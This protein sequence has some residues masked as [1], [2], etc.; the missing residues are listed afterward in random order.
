MGTYKHFRENSCKWGVEKEL[1][2]SIEP[3]LTEDSVKAYNHLGNEQSELKSGKQ[4]PLLPDMD[5]SINGI[6]NWEC[7]NHTNDSSICLK[8]CENDPDSV[9]GLV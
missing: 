9:E 7:S 3:S 8:K 1:E 5:E 2:C 6:P 4:C